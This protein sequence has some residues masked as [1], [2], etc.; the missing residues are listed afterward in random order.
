MS[1]IALLALEDLQTLALEET[2]VGATEGEL[3][4]TFY[5]RLDTL[6]A[7]AS[8]QGHE[9]QEQW[10]IRVPNKVKGAP[11]YRLRCRKTVVDGVATYVQTIK[12]PNAGSTIGKTDMA[13]N[14][15]EVTE[16]IFALFKSMSNQGMCKIRYFFR[17]DHRD[18]PLQVDVFKLADGR[19]ANWVKIDYEHKAGERD[20]PPSWPA[21]LVDIIRGDTK[22]PQAQAFIRDLYETVFNVVPK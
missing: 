19:T 13:E 8:A 4:T 11:D 3:E 16:E 14:N 22:D 20:E 10:Q 21:G 12:L 18:D 9:E 2:T 5:A 15:F 1:H 7:L 17:Q 6:R